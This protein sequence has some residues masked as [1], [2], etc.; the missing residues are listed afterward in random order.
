MNISIDFNEIFRKSFPINYTFT[1]LEMRTGECEA[2]VAFVDGKFYLHHNSSRRAFG[3]RAERDTLYLRHKEFFE[4]LVNQIKLT[5]QYIGSTIPNFLF[6]LETQ[7]NP[8]CKYF[9][10]VK[11]TQL[12]RVKGLVH[13]SFCSPRLCNGILLLPM[14]YNQNIQALEA[15]R[16]LD[17]KAAEIPW[18]S[19]E[20]KLFWRGSNKGK[21][22]ELLN[23][24]WNFS[25]TPRQRAISLLK[26]RKDSDVKFGF[27]PWLQFA[28]HRYILSVAGNTYSSV[29]KHALRSGSCILR[30]EERMFEWF[31]PFVQEWKHYI[32]VR[33]DLSDLP[34]KLDWIKE[35]DMQAKK[36]GENARRLGIE[37]F[38]PKMLS[39]YTYCGISYFSKLADENLDSEFI[40]NGFIRIRKVCSSKLSKRRDC[41]Y[42]A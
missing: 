39:C 26:N 10:R 40:V 1:L 3:N 28:K 4:S 37:L 8:T 14:S 36:I 34:T 7:D 6:N 25:E 35:N 5:N 11:E 12:A 18:R 17:A 32:P 27:V 9:R 13:H 29:F 23:F 16:K 30:Q 2:T 15:T 38:S 41:L 19:R 42:L 22:S 31:E 33:W 21:I 20:K 24:D